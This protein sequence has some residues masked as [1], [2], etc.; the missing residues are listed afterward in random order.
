MLLE[1]KYRLLCTRHLICDICHYSHSN[2]NINECNSMTCGW[3]VTYQSAKHTKH[4]QY[5]IY[6]Q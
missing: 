3:T 2:I 5:T 1:C 6:K 4:I